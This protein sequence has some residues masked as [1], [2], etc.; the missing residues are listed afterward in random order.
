MLIIR[1]KGLMLTYGFASLLGSVFA[2][3]STQ[4]ETERLLSAS[5]TNAS[6]F[7]SYN[8]IH[9]CDMSV[10]N[11]TDGSNRR[12][13]RICVYGKHCFTK[14][15]MSV[16]RTLRFGTNAQ[17]PKKTTK[18]SETKDENNNHAKRTQACGLPGSWQPQLQC[19]PK[20]RKSIQS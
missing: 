1:I 8:F 3:I 14:R 12:D 16:A 13:C 10:R 19:N 20:E 15:C 9:D 4:S 5:T 17:E 7:C 11:G 6:V 2:R 18:S